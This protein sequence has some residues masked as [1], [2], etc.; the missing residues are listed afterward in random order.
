M[1]TVVTEWTNQET[2]DYFLTYDEAVEAML[3][4]RPDDQ[5]ITGVYILKDCEYCYGDGEVIADSGVYCGEC[6]GSGSSYPATDV[7]V[8]PNTGTFGSVVECRS[9]WTYEIVFHD[10]GITRIVQTTEVGGGYA[11]LWNETVAEI[12]E[13]LEL[14]GRADLLEFAPPWDDTDYPTPFNSGYTPR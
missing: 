10:G 12:R 9:S 1:Y 2:K 8:C 11:D 3:E 5:E 14:I 4:P 7:I 6:S 13:T